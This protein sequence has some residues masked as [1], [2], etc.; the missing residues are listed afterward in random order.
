MIIGVDFDNTIISYD[1]VFHKLASESG[2]TPSTVSKNKT[3]VRDFLRDIGKEDAWTQLQGRAYGPSIQLATPFANVLEFFRKAEQLGH[4]TYIVSHKTKFPYAGEKYDLHQS[5]LNWLL[6]EK[7]I[8]APEQLGKTLFFENT[9][10]KKLNRINQL[11]CDWFIDDL[12]EF[13]NLPEFSSIVTRCLFDPFDCHISY[14]TGPRCSNW[15]EISEK[16]LG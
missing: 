14:V 15:S 12:P 5:A 11:K 1:S 4:Q 9:K 16:A 6:R 8:D 13:L 7:F 3:A 2:L 10:E